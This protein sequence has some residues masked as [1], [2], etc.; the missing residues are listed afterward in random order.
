MFSEWFFR[1]FVQQFQRN[2]LGLDEEDVRTLVFLD[3]S[4]VHPSVEPLAS[5]DGGIKYMFSPSNA[6]ILIQPMSQGGTLSCKGLYRWKQ[7]EVLESLGEREGEQDRREKGIS[8]IK[9]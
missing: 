3:K 1:N 8:K 9:M 4:P 6:S 7:L 5:E 2:D